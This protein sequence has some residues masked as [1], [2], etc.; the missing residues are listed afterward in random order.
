MT[1]WI[2]VTM[3][4]NTVHDFTETKEIV[5]I[6]KAKKENLGSNNGKLYEIELD[7][8]SVSAVWGST[9]LD[10]KMSKVQIGQQVKITYL[11]METNPRTKRSYK[12]F[13]VHY[14]NVE[15]EGTDIDFASHLDNM[16][17]TF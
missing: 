2:K 16:F 6:L 14:K 12:N 13:E 10:S 15:Q 17:E 8:G 1:D 7:S 11:G 3:E 9:V 4:D 5:G